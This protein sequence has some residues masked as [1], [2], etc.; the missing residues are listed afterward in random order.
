MPAAELRQSLD[1]KDHVSVGHADDDEVVRVVRD[2]RRERAALQPGAGDETE[3]DAAGREMPFDDRDLREV[4]S[5]IRHRLTALDD[6]LPLERLGHDLVLDEADRAQ[7]PA[8]P[9]NRE[10]AGSER[11]H[12]N[13]LPHPVGDLDAWHVLDG[14]AALEHGRR[15]EAHEIG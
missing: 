12:A 7:A 9:R 10:V 2:A 1:R 15:L 13:G 6:G 4:A 8:A 11:C 14:T 3:P 5:G